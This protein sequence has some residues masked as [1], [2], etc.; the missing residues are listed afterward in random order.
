MDEII[1]AIPVFNGERFLAATLD[2]LVKQTR[3]P[4][5]IVVFDNGST[6]RTLEICRSYNN[7]K[8]EIR[9]NETNLGV[10]GNANRCLSLASQ[11]KFLHLLMADDLVLPTFL[12]KVLPPLSGLT[13][14]GLGYVFHEEI[15]GHGDVIGPSSYRPC[16]PARRVGLKEFLI[17]QSQLATVLIS[18]V[19]FRTDYQDAPCQVRNLP[20]VADG[21]LLADWAQRTDGII[22]VPEYLC[23]YRLS[24]FNATSLH[25]RNIEYFV[26]DEWRLMEDIRR[27]IPESA[28]R[29]W[30][31]LWKL[32]CLFAARAEV[33]LRMFADTEPAYAR[34]IAAARHKTVGLL[35]TMAG[36]TSVA[37]RDAARKL[38]GQ[39]S[40]NEEIR[41]IQSP[42]SGK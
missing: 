29:R 17:P 6:D 21:L 5:R 31:R 13:G 24:D 39:P 11:T 10:L 19:V 7:L 30:L 4:D 16:G 18:G 35:A 32:R 22:E 40:R 8:I 28:M 2:S 12:E 33:K 42:R 37:L 36:I 38:K 3:R 23:Q 20:Q 41:G 27:W 25:V 14:Q 15:N 9:V 34:E 1:T 26:L